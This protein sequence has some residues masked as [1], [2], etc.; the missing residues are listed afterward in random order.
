MEEKNNN[1]DNANPIISFY[2]KPLVGILGSIAS[3]IGLLLAVYFYYSSVQQRELTYYVHPAKAIIARTDQVSRLTFS[4]DKQ[5]IS[6]NVTAAQIAFWNSGRLPIKP[7]NILSP[8]I[9]KLE[10]DTPIIEAIIRKQNRDVINVKLNKDNVDKGEIR[11]DWDIL[12][13]NDGAILQI[14]FAGG[15]D[16]LIKA[17]GVIEGQGEVDELSFSGKIRTPIEQYEWQYSGNKTTAYLFLTTGAIMLL[18]VIILS[19]IRRTK[20]K[21][22]KIMILLVGYPLF[23]V[24]YGFIKL[25]KSVPPGPP[26][27]F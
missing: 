5:P 12:E 4:I 6:S 16:K 11:I 8:F 1:S 22:G 23:L 21:K 19:Y 15:T 9:V 10:E 25:L 7:E 17:K 24:I 18:A 3:I 27:G 20:K 2:S 26:F 14:I 13:K